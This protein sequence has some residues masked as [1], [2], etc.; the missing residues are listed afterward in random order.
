VM[1]GGYS[2]VVTDSAPNP[3]F[4]HAGQNVTV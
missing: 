2:L 4:A 1:G 3:R